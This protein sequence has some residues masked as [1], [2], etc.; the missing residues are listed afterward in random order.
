[1]TD[2]QGRLRPYHYTLYRRVSM[3]GFPTICA[4]T[5]NL[6]RQRSYSLGYDGSLLNGLQALTEWNAD[7]VSGAL[8]SAGRSTDALFPQDTPTGT[9]LGLI[10]ASYY[11]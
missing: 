8:L 5:Q 4:M 11:L 2:N 3:I 1:M 7:F 9:R 6:T 10:A